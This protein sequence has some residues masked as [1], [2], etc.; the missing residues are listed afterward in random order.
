MSSSVATP[1]SAHLRRIRA[2]LEAAIDLVHPNMP[3]AERLLRF[4]T[5]DDIARLR[6]ALANRVGEE[7]E[8]VASLDDLLRSVLYFE[9]RI[10]FALLGC[11]D[12]SEADS[13]CYGDLGAELLAAEF[14]R[15]RQAEFDGWLAAH[16]LHPILGT[17]RWLA[18]RERLLVASRAT[19]GA[20]SRVRRRRRAGS[21]LAS[22]SV[23]Q[24][25]VPA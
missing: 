21:R 17:E 7:R 20:I 11:T 22:A 23:G 8:E 3:A 12:M 18:D 9:A 5:K 16:G 24:A 2:V 4:S 10:T 25:A 13:L 1:S 19:C 15:E 14:I 6:E